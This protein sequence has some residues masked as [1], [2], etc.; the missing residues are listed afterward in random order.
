MRSCLFAL[1][2]S[3]AL[4]AGVSFEKLT[5]RPDFISEGVAV[6]DF[7]R[8]GHPDII[9]GHLLWTGPHFGTAVEIAPPPARPLDPAFGYS[10]CCLAAAVDVNVDGWPDLIVTGMPGE[11]T[12]LRL[13]PGKGGGLW[14]EKVLLDTTG[15]ESP[16]LY[17][18]KGDGRPSWVCFHDNA[19][20]FLELPWGKPDEAAR[21]RPIAP[22][23]AERFG[24][25]THGLGA[26]D[27]NGDGRIDVVVKDG[28]FEQPAEESAAWRF[29]PVVFAPDEGGAQMLVFDVNGDGRNDV[30]TSLNA[31]AYGLSWFE[32]KEDGAFV[33]HRILSPVPE[34]NRA[35]G[36]SQLHALAAGDLNRDGAMDFV[37]GKRHW[38]HGANRD[39][40][41]NSDSVLYWFEAKRDGK[42]EAAF[43]PHEIDRESGVGAQ[44]VVAD[45]NGDGKPD[46]VVANKCG[47]FVFLQTAASSSIDNASDRDVD[48]G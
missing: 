24:P 5:L 7:N 45:L 34:E 42:G 48:P 21:F 4:H 20:G 10:D 41:P 46:I 15:N 38:A 16:G 27:L 43:I 13:N 44:V 9:A 6:A 33:E 22:P 31:H 18:L 39:Y 19:P 26:G 35:H 40:E 1:F 8:D 14:P 25:Y 3:P 11:A 47:V 37:T 29:H 28:W 36:F 32:R 17:D 12:R 30:V 23:D 2:L